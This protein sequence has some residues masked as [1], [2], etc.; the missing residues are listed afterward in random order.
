MK[1][2]RKEKKTITTHDAVNDAKK[3]V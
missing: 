2:V 1:Y 3:L